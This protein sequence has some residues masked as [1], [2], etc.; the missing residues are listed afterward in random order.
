MSH[1]TFVRHGQANSAARDE[2]SYDRLSPLGHQQ[3]RWLGEHL[4]RAGPHHAHV[5]SG[6]LIRHVETASSMG[7]GA[8]AVQDARLNELP[9]F[10][11]ASLLEAQQG[12]ALP[13]EREGFVEHLPQVFAAWQRDEIAGAP[14]RFADFE[15]R[16]WAAVTEIA[17]TKGPSLIVTSGG[18]IAIVMRRVMGLDIGATARLALAIMNTSVHRLYPIGMDLSPVLFNAVPHLETPERSHAQTHF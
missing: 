16:V 5:F 13:V 12:L 6:T 10:T 4:D 11:L 18:L 9:Y 8:V 14:E 17:A 3:A 1:L 2:Q 15:A 7:L